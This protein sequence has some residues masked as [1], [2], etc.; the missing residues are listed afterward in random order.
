MDLR[1]YFKVGG[2]LHFVLFRKFICGNSWK[3]GVRHHDFYSEVV[4]WGVGHGCFYFILFYFGRASTPLVA[5]HGDFLVCEQT[6]CFGHSES[7]SKMWLVYD[8]HP[9]F[10]HYL[11]EFTSRCDTIVDAAGQ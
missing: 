4:L 7:R 11:V 3:K 1:L 10:G 6:I 2:R 9:T 5:P 8:C